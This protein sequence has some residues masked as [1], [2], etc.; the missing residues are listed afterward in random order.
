MKV[1][2][3]RQYIKSISKGN[4]TLEL[5]GL[6]K[7]YFL[8]MM[9]GQGQKV[10]A[11]ITGAASFA[12]NAKEQLFYEFVQNAYDASAD[13][14][15]FYA[16][17]EFLIV[18]NNGEPF[19]TDLDIFDLPEGEEPRDGQLYNFLAK[20]KS[21]KLND[22]EKLGKYGQGSKLLYTLLADINHNVNTEELLKDAIINNKKGPYLV[23]WHNM[24][25]LDAWLINDDEWIPAQADDVENHILFAKILM[26]YYPI[27]PGQDLERFSNEEAQRAI[28]AFTELVDPPRNKSFLTRGTALIIPLG[29][30][31]YE[32]IIEENNLEN[33]R[34]RLG[35]FASI[36]ADQER[37][38]GKSL[39][40]IYVM[41][42][43]VEQHPVRSL[44][45][46][47]EEA[48][49]K[50]HYH[51]AFN[52]IFAEKNV[53]NFFKGLPILQTKYRFGFILDSQ[54]LEVDD[55]RQRISD[56]DK[57][58]EQLKQAFSHLVENLKY[59]YQE[60][61]GKFDYIYQSIISS[62][63]EQNSEEEKKIRLAFYDAI[64]PFLYEFAYTSED[65]YVPF[66]K[67]CEKEKET[68]VLLKDIGID[69]HWIDNDSLRKY[70]NHF[71]Q[72]K[73]LRTLGFAEMLQMAD[74]EKLSAWIKGMSKED[75]KL[76]HNNCL[77]CISDIEDIQ[78][79][80]SNENNL[81]SW[82]ELNSEINVYF[83]AQ[84]TEPMFV[85]QEYIVEPMCEEYDSDDYTTLFDKIKANLAE[86]RETS[87]G[88]DAACQTLCMIAE[89]ETD[90]E[91][92]IKNEIAVLQNWRGDYL[93][94]SELFE[95]RLDGTILFDNFRIK[96]SIPECIKQQDWLIDKQDD[97]TALWTWIVNHFDDIKQEDGWGIDTDAYL[98]DI[99][100]A[101]KAAG[102]SAAGSLLRLYLDENGKP[103]E[104]PCQSVENFE[105]LSEAEYEKL[106]ISYSGYNFVPYKYEKVLS[107]APFM[108][109]TLYVY[110]LIDPNQFID[111]DTLAI[112]SKI[113]SD[114]FLLKYRVIGDDNIFRVQPLNGGK[115]YT[116]ELNTELRR[117]LVEIK[118]Y[119]V[120]QKVQAL[121]T[122]ET[123]AF[124]I[125][126]DDFAKSVVD[127][128]SDKH[129]IFP[130]IRNCSS[131]VVEHYINSLSKI[132]IDYKISDSDI[133]WQIIKFAVSRDN[134]E[135][136]FKQIIFDCIRHKNEELPETIKDSVFIAYE[137][138]YNLYALNADY[139]EE[140]EHIDSFLDCLPSANDA[141]WFKDQFY[142]D[143]KEIVSCKE[144]YDEIK[145]TYLSIE[146]L[147]FCLDYSLNGEPDY[148]NL[149]IDDK[150]SLS[151]ALSMIKA[152]HY[153][154]FD[155][156]FNISGFDAECQV[157]ADQS[158]LNDE[159]K[160]PNEMQKWLEQNVDAIAL[161][162]NIRTESESYISVRR[163]I[164][165][166]EEAISI[167]DFED[168]DRTD[169]TLE[170][171][172]N[173]KLIY[174]YGDNAYKNIKRIIDRLPEGIENMVFLK[175]TGDVIIHET[176][177]EVI[178]P[179][180]TLD[181]YKDNSCFMSIYTWRPIF[182]DMLKN[183]KNVK[184]FFKDNIVY[185]YDEDSLLSKHKLHK[186]PK[187]EIS[188]KAH[189]GDY[190][191]ISTE[192]YKIWKN[193]P[194]SRGILIKTS[195]KPIGNN[196]TMLKN[197]EQ[198]FSKAIENKEFGY[199]TNGLVVVQYPNTD[200]ISAIK[201]IEKHIADME[202]FLQPFIVLQGLYVDQLERLEQIAEE[203]GT[204]I[205]TIV[206][207]SDGSDNS[208]NNSEADANLKV[209]DDKLANVKELAES[210][211]ADE[212]MELADKKDKILEILH[213]LEEAEDETQESQVR[214]TIGYIGELIYEQY[215]LKQGK[216]YKYAAIEGVGDYDFHNIT[217]RTYV[218]VKTTLY[219]L[220]EGT[221]PF[222]LHKSQNMFM[223]K[224]PNE[225][226][227]IV[228]ISL[229]DL[230]LQ[231]SYERLRDKYGK[232]ANP[233]A[234]ERLNNACKKI[235][236][237]YWTGAQIEVFDALA[238]E[239]SI[240]IEKKV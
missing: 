111:F 144:I 137:H 61:R 81:Y 232:E 62:R 156:Y 52:P 102:I 55:S 205:M 146:Q 22:D 174:V 196:F 186:S 40:H 41:G 118:F 95:E 180:F 173:S 119:Y 47:F 233:L 94:F 149:E 77:D 9:S 188:V 60:D 80:R 194:E 92:E 199:D 122:S 30:G 101:Y 143:K 125:T 19:F 37:N 59:L 74:N 167:P 222:Y 221:A 183:D 54:I 98:R 237:K 110:D 204:D 216:E 202:F 148:D 26:S 8:N 211:D 23:S 75:Y 96:G 225:K 87:M 147:R 170:W 36:T 145:N 72:D 53:V 105:R 159:E 16:N 178:C 141:E 49:N 191:E 90:Y 158:L 195:K 136:E 99:Q 33:V 39:K 7:E 14:L 114:G 76:F 223:Q 135:N 56:T 35:G 138:E 226:Y 78:V 240:K 124:N 151:E 234:D 201:M 4:E 169:S 93:P 45:V 154:G 126:R 140:N 108:M 58:C 129:L 17:E 34:A 31:K 185:A 217:D 42:K 224:H 2:N 152:N 134:E 1:R 213:E 113:S 116:N 160:L 238:P 172:L 86:L 46:D 18:L 71:S 198:V 13:T 64:R 239:Y 68:N 117:A 235:A 184:V 121:I 69:L 28:R 164:R 192:P 168:S 236:E 21:L 150:E 48:G 176:P 162:E 27:A 67:V 203:K 128:I 219:S 84:D 230:D 6:N 165:D 207:T 104:E 100:N 32:A 228:R 123:N 50:F 131:A 218:D 210:F 12:N 79:F 187:L 231:K 179:S 25:Q 197:R 171:L 29:K 107:S 220:K 97:D 208:G 91:D 175:Y 44:F 127:K 3:L 89:N 51:F 181:T 212:L 15:L 63:P 24:S 190:K 106:Q 209:D 65:T 132:S 206:Q 139:Q 115:N 163:Y 88:R 166:N 112:L 161:F 38:E 5:V 103:V 200:K 57:T 189:E 130:L 142:G 109:N 229:N 66:E 85:G 70:K 133:R 155:K 83:M 153:E 182:L 10:D 120:P 177:K 73:K 43:E 157:F 215:L 193:M 20:G 227:H 214:Q 11:L 82:D